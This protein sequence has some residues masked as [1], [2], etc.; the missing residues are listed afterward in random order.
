MFINNLTDIIKDEVLENQY[1]I[2]DI[3]KA[4][5]L[6]LQGFD[7]VSIDN[8]QYYIFYKTELLMEFLQKG[9]QNKWL[10]P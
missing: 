2:C 3:D 7:P 5:D 10:Q 8:K 1:Y 4:K 9:E 6:L